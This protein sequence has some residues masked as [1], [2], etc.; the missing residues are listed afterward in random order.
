MAIKIHSDSAQGS[1]LDDDNDGSWISVKKKGSKT[2]PLIRK[3]SNDKE[4]DTSF[5]NDQDTSSSHPVE[6][7]PEM[8]TMLLDGGDFHDISTSDGSIGSDISAAA[9]NPTTASTPETINLPS[10]ETN[11]GDGK[12]KM[13]EQRI[14]QLEMEL[15]QKDQQLKE[16]RIMHAKAL[17]E[18]KE[19]CE[20]SMQDLQL[21]LYISETRLKT[22]IDALEQHVESVASNLSNN[23]TPSSPM[24]R[25]GGGMEQAPPSSP[26]LISRVL[27]QQ[28]RFEK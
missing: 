8:S 13:E 4:N 20:D 5:N 24:R 28:N 17:R 21:R 25:G 14:R 26:L 6:K 16:E 22:Y 2:E 9:H 23:Y 27:I 3:D 12:K 18:E 15:V 11:L 7:S 1:S 19:R 10:F